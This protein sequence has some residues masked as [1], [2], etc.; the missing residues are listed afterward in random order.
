MHGKLGCGFLKHLDTF[1]M[2]RVGMGTDDHANVAKILSQSLESLLN[3]LKKMGMPGIDESRCFAI[4]Q[5]GIGIIGGHGFPDKPMKIIQYLHKTFLSLSQ[6][7]S[8][9][10]V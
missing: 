4:N 5:V 8:N 7:I 10:S 6:A 9:S 2:V 1:D 3:V